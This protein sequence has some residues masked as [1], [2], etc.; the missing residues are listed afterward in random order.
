MLRRRKSLRDESFFGS[1]H[2]LQIK[3]IQRK[4]SMIN[5]H[6]H[7]EP[8]PLPNSRKGIPGQ[9]LT[10]L[11]IQWF[12]LIWPDIS[13]LTNMSGQTRTKP[14]SFFFQVSRT[15]ITIIIFSFL[16]NIFLC[17]SLKI[18]LYNVTVSILHFQLPIQLKLIITCVKFQVVC[19]EK[20]LLKT[21]ISM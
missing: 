19:I 20:A 15:I 14:D 1:S 2:D 18:N 12:G 8:S 21:A 3:A 16:Q 4:G 13:I 11:R 10:G 17:C 5:L 9:G 7:R 6:S